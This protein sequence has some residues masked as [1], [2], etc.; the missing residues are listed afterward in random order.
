MSLRGLVFLAV[1]VPATLL[2]SLVSL[3][4]GL[5]RAPKALHDAVHRGWSRVLLAAAGV[6]VRLEGEEHL[7]PEAARV[8][9]CNHQS[10]FDILALMAAVPASVRFVAKAELSDVPVFAGAMRSA[11]HVFVDRTNPRHA[12]SEMRSF[13]DRMRR[14]GLAVAVFPE[15]TRSTD[16]RLRRFKRAPFLL[17]IEAGTPVVPVAV[18]GGGRVLP[19]GKLLARPGTV[20]IR[21]GRP[22]STEGLDPGDRGELA[23]RVRDRVEALLEEAR[24][25]A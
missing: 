2:F 9:A 11:G 24:A 17:A 10:V 15:G 4:G 5:L 3:T 22:V 23:G 21:V 12:I 25:G 14:D 16:G 19:K 1:G 8:L 13:G 6:D 7:R 18:E 20:S